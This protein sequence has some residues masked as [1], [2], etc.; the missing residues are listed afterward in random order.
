MHKDS[1][2]MLLFYLFAKPVC[3]LIG[4]SLTP[5]RLVA[6]EHMWLKQS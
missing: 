5:Q 1:P 3:G 6:A 2:E 4:L